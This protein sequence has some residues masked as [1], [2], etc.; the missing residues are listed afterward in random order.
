MKR[1]GKKSFVL[2]MCMI[3]T[4]VFC[5]SGLAFAA[6]ESELRNDLSDVKQEQMSSAKK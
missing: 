1:L 6:T 4:T 3:L 2:L 5:C